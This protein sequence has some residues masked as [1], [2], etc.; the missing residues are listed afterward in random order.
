MPEL[1]PNQHKSVIGLAFKGFRRYGGVTFFTDRPAGLKVFPE[2]A[3]SILFLDQ[4]EP[5]G[6]FRIYGS[7]GL[8]TL[9]RA[10]RPVSL[11]LQGKSITIAGQ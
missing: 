6:V 1:T 4:L 11:P 9:R 3:D 8:G 7:N 5:D 10:D 2:C